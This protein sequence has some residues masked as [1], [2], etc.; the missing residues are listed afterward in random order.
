VVSRG[1]RP[2]RHYVAA[3]KGPVHAREMLDADLARLSRERLVVLHLDDLDELLC[4][5]EVDRLVPH[6]GPNRAGIEDL[7][8]TLSA[9]VRLPDE[10]TVR[11]VLPAETSPTLPTDQAQAALRDRATDEAS[12]S[13]RAAMAVRSMGRRQLPLGLATALVSATVAYGA[14]YLASTVDNLAGRGLLVVT[15]GIALTVAWVVSWMVIESTVLDWRQSARQA[16]AYDLIARATLE[17][18]LAEPAS[19]GPSTDGPRVV[20]DQDQGR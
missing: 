9:A 16:F 12:A 2:A 13:W 5:P 1:L 14:G 11:V 15:A 3:M 4:E 20:P 19:G 17:V 8:L 6:R 18:V 7:A 10:L